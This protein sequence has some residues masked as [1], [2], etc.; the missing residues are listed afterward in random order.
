MILTRGTYKVSGK[1]YDRTKKKYVSFS[2]IVEINFGS[3]DSEENKSAANRKIADAI[4]SVLLEDKNR[5]VFLNNW[6]SA[7]CSVNKH[8]VE[9]L[10]KKDNNQYLLG[11]TDR[12][13]E[14]IPPLTKL[15]KVSAAL[16]GKYVL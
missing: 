3:L 7:H 5:D 12:Y 6:F 15:K 10:F 2:R 14:Y 13:Y 9:I 16:S 11:F 1:G 4:F 8:T